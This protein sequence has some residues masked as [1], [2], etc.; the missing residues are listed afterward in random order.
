MSEYD[1]KYGLLCV[2]PGTVTVELQDG[3]K[4][5]FERGDVIPI[6]MDATLKV[7]NNVLEFIGGRVK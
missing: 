7:G 6:F 5:E 2:G 3:A 4:R 1:K